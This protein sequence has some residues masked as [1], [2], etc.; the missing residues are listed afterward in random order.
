MGYF[1]F[2]HVN[3]CAYYPNKTRLRNR[4]ALVEHVFEKM[5]SGDE[6]P[7]KA[8][9]LPG[10]DPPPAPVSQN[11]QIVCHDFL[12][13]PLQHEQTQAFRQRNSIQTLC[14]ALQN[15]FHLKCIAHHLSVFPHDVDEFSTH[16]ELSIPLSSS[17]SC[18]FSFFRAISE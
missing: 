11:Q 10:V 4:H 6:N 17:T 3:I 2:P 16:A 8:R 12:E 14:V 18:S 9:S 7:A 15:V 13:K 5:K 1:Q